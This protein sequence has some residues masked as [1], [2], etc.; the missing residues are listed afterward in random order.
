MPV[1]FTEAQTVPYG[2]MMDCM[3]QVVKKEGVVALWTGFSAYYLRCAPFAMVILLT[4]EFLNPMFKSVFHIDRPS[5]ERRK[6]Q[7]MLDRKR[8]E[9]L[10]KTAG[11]PLPPLHALPK[12]AAGAPAGYFQDYNPQPESMLDKIN[13]MIWGH[14]DPRPTKKAELRRAWT[15]P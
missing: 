9:E 11:V 7:R 15:N 14:A 1:P 5:L 4:V 8:S 2:G 10:L 13:L 6:T 12:T 3:R